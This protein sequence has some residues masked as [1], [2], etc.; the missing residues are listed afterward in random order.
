M[1]HTDQMHVST[2][3][4]LSQ[5]IFCFQ[6]DF[7]GSHT[8]ERTYSTDCTCLPVT[9]LP[10]VLQFHTLAEVTGYHSFLITNQY[11]AVQ[12]LYTFFIYSSATF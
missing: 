11:F 4:G 5:L 7:F 1:A 10:T 9:A 3:P 6:I 2:L 8:L 12:I